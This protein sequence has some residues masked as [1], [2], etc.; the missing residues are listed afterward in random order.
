MC[1]IWL[2]TTVSRILNV[3]AASLLGRKWHAVLQKRM[4][5]E[6]HYNGA[7]QPFM[8]LW[9]FFRTVRS[10]PRLATMVRIL[11][12]GNWGFYPEAAL[13]TGQDLQLPSDELELVR[14]AIHEAGITHLEASIMENLPKR[15]RRPL[16]ALLWVCLPNLSIISAHV[17][18]CD[19]ALRA[20][21]EQALDCQKRAEPAA[22]LRQL[23]D[24]YFFPEVAI[25]PRKDEA[26]P[27]ERKSCVLSIY[28][29]LK[30]SCYTEPRQ[31]K[32]PL[33]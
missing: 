25:N 16:M 17:P 3:C 12:I 1:W 29:A 28:R 5:T 31:R 10:N 27:E 30:L 21:L 24:L 2:C 19:F 13:S 14:S 33:G 6:W 20:V 22:P 23:K 8:T 32:Q 7:R 26:E 4:Y 18:P 11:H 9:K 15:D